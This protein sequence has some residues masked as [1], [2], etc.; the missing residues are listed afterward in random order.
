MVAL[1]ARMQHERNYDDEQAG[2]RG[3]E[4]SDI[5]PSAAWRWAGHGFCA[6]GLREYH[7]AWLATRTAT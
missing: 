6:Q 7:H 5:D 1:N 3:P 4:A 2:K